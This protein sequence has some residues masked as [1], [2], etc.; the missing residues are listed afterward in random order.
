MKSGN[1]GIGNKKHGISGHVPNEKHFTGKKGK[2]A[3]RKK[4]ER[5]KRV[6]VNKYK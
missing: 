6:H 4:N 3:V 1:K 5:S 2:S